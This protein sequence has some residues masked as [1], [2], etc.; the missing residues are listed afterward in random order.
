MFEDE[1]KKKYI[2]EFHG[3]Y[4]Y[5]NPKIY[6]PNT[7][8]KKRSIIFGEIYNKTMDRMYRIKALGYE[9]IYIWERDYRNY[10]KDKIKTFIGHLK[11]YCTKL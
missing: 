3:D 9:I 2:V 11:D 8:C 4:F 5:G 1:Y 7:I 6:D 10:L